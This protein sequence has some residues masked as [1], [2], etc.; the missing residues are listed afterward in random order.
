MGPHDA[1]ADALVAGF[2]SLGSSAISDA[3]DRL[4][5]AGQPVGLRP[6]MPELSLCGRAFTVRYVTAQA[7]KGETVGDFIDDVPAGAVVVID[8]G[9]RI[10]ATVWGDLM[11]TVAARNGLAGTVIDGVCRDTPKAREMRYPIYSRASFMRTGKDR[12]TVAAV[13]VPVNLASHR[14]APDD[15]VFG[16]ADGVVIIPATRADEVLTAGNEIAAAEDGIRALLADGLRLDEARSRFSYHGLQ[17]NR[18][19]A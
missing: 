16:D 1:A 15:I 11:T 2:A 13:G 9:G 14:V 18:D 17:T 19:R 12:V 6:V 8:N 4:G 7:G 5:I 10:D 3:L